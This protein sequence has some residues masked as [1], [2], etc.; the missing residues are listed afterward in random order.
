MS[1]KSLFENSCRFE[2]SIVRDVV[3]CVREERK[4]WWVQFLPVE[5]LRDCPTE[6]PA[7]CLRDCPTEGKV[8]SN[9]NFSEE[10]RGRSND[11]LIV[12]LAFGGFLFALFAFLITL[13]K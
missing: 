5:C 11:R 2:A 8:Q 1:G 7:E 4:N 13:I 9:G 10:G 12:L 6:G 3:L